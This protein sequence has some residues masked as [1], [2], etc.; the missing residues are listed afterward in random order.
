MVAEWVAVII[1]LGEYISR[2]I[3]TRPARAY[4]F[5]FFG[6]I[7]LIAILPTIL[8]LGNF[9]FLKSARALRIIRMLR[10]L[11]LAKV[12]RGSQIHTAEESYGVAA[13][14]VFI[15][16]AVLLFALLVMGTLLY[17]VE[18]QTVYFSNIPAAM[19]WSLKVFLGGIAV[20]APE[21]VWGE[22]LFIVARFVGLLLLGLLIGVV[23]N[24]FKILLMGKK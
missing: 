1:F 14:N 7:D 2:L 13:L 24:V 15:Y 21:T 8:G 6:I 17:L 3:V 5:S 11:R 23:G 12:S 18:P 4:V 10:M 22:T 9:T 20:G 19:W 16:G